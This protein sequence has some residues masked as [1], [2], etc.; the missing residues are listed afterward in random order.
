MHTVRWWLFLIFIFLVI[1]VIHEEH[2]I[3]REG[4]EPWL[5]VTRHLQDL[6]QS[7]NYQFLIWET[8]QEALRMLSIHGSAAQITE[9][10]HLVNW[11][12]LTNRRG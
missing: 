4:F 10:K 5:F 7:L 12:V 11:K 9:E 1:K 2:W 6:D 8:G 3:W